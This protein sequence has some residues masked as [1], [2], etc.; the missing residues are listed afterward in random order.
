MEIGNGEVRVGKKVQIG[1]QWPK[2]PSRMSGWMTLHTMSS[3]RQ[4]KSARKWARYRG[5]K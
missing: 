5:E 4:D 2:L 3:W 1:L